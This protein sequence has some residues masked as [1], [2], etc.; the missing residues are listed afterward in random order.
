MVCLPPHSPELNPA[1]TARLYRRE[2]WPSRRVLAGGHGAVVADAARAAWD[3]LQAGAGRL[4]SP[5]SHP[6]LPRSV[7]TS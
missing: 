4:R 1:G 5:T 2:R 7:Q 6:R 3:A